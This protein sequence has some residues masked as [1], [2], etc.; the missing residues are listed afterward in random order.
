VQVPVFDSGDRTAKSQIA[1]G[2][3]ANNG[4]ANLAFDREKET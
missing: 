4:T 1:S 2:D 3:T